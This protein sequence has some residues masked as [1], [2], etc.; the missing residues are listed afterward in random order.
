MYSFS[1]HDDP[2]SRMLHIIEHPMLGK[3][4]DKRIQAWIADENAAV[5]SFDEVNVLFSHP[6]TLDGAEVSFDHSL[7]NS[8][9]VRNEAGERLIEYRYN[10][11]NDQYSDEIPTNVLDTAIVTAKRVEFCSQIGPYSPIG[12]FVEENEIVEILELGQYEIDSTT[13]E[14]VR[15]VKV[16]G[17]GKAGWLKSNYLTKGTWSPACEDSLYLIGGVSYDLSTKTYINGIKVI[18]KPENYQGACVQF[19][20]LPTV[21]DY[22][23]EGCIISANRDWLA[24]SET[25]DNNTGIIYIYDINYNYSSI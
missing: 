1:P 22:S 16:E 24:Y 13:M 3:N 5:E 2:S 7:G 11:R 23:I 25:G 15:W 6:L 17:K 14:G 4:D 9:V 12:R 21:F 10:Y 19:V 20:N 8:I 18:E